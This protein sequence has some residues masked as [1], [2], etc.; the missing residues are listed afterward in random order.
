MD[1]LV[2]VLQGCSSVSR[3]ERSAAEAAL[4][5]VREGFF[6]LGRGRERELDWNC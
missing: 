2:E 3:A 5:Q 1:N 6:I 4:T